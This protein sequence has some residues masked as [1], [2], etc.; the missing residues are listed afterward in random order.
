MYRG[1]VCNA[2]LGKIDNVVDH[3]LELKYVKINASFKID[4]F[5]SIFRILGLLH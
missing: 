4:N 1:S 3:I 5:G 2:M